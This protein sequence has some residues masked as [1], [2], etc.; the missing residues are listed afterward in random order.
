[1]AG[2]P[3]I[4]LNKACSLDIDP[5]GTNRPAL[6]TFEHPNPFMFPVP[7]YTGKKGVLQGQDAV[8]LSQ[9]IQLALSP[10]QNKMYKVCLSKSVSS[11]ATVG[12][13]AYGH[14]WETKA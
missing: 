1:M 5:P 10:W 11:P 6:A 9:V 7:S 4:S 14:P 8:I 2:K 3:F 12:Y 13:V